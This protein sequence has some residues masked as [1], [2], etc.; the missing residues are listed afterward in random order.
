MSDRA[1]GAALSGGAVIS[2]LGGF[3]ASS[4]GRQLQVP[5]RAERLLAY[6]ALVGRPVRR[7][8]LAGTLWLDSPDEK[9]AASL[10]STLWRL[11]PQVAPLVLAGATHVA[12]A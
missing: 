10:R 1:G 12:L 11:P 4:D 6:L 7:P 9:A 3:A 5:A 2:V 8:Q